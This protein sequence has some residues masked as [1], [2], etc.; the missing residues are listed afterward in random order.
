MSIRALNTGLTGLTASRIGID[1]A[2]NN[3]ANANT[4]GYTRQRV[5]FAPHLP[6]S[7]I[8]G[9]IGNGVKVLD[10]AR[11]RDAFLDERVRDSS[12]SLA[13]LNART[14]LLSRTESTLGEP[15]FGINAHLDSLFESF[16]ELGLDPTSRGSKAEVVHRLDALTSRIRQVATE[17][18]SIA[19]STRDDLDSDIGQVNRLS[20]RVAQLND[21][22]ARSNSDTTPNN[23]LDRR[24]QAVNDLVE[25]TGA[26]ARL[27]NEGRYHITLNG[28][29]LV[30]G[31]K[32]TDLAFDGTTDTISHTASGVPLTLGGSIGGQQQF[33]VEDVPAIRTGLSTL[34]VEVS[35]ALNAQ[36]AL[37]FVTSGTPGG[38]LLSYNPL[39]PAASVAVV[40]AD[41]GDLASS[42][43]DATPFPIHNGENAMRLAELRTSLSAL[44]GTETLPN[45]ARQLVAD[46]GARVS[47]ARDSAA[48]QLDLATSARLS[49]ETEHGVSLDEEM[50]E[51]MRYQRAYAA[52]ARVITTADAALDVLVNRTG[53]VGR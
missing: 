5:E 32:S 50:V 43:V 26:T 28:L 31:V 25:L 17:V 47:A 30:L 10:I 49:R 1:T 29:S 39:D 2:S 11:T 15:E 6:T 48:A 27:D 38:P 36:H 46:V 34:A 14:D 3:I 45:V 19:Q 44:G 23:L 20:E 21:A 33:L 16:E 37:G 53:L 13:A 52:A 8:F 42:D 18:D 7:L 4:K 35:D 41:P 51:L 9:E 40:I 22:V 12:S 24:D